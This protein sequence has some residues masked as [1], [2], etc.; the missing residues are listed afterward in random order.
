MK[1]AFIALLLA[2]SAFAQGPSGG[3]TSACGPKDASFDV[4]LDSAQHTLTQPEPGKALVYFIQEKGPD[5]FAATTKVGLD[6][7][8]VGANKNDS[9]FAVPVEPGEHHV[10]E[11]MQ[12]FR[13]HLLG[14]VHFTAEAGKN[15][16]F[17]AQ[18]IFGEESKPHLFLAAADSD[19]ATYLIE[20]F[21]LSVSTP[22][23]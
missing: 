2:T 5:S 14:L 9:Y 19:Q 18:I 8:W 3:A 15:Y 13:G 21:P 20:S 6:G 10:C 23:K 4:K 11:N 12:S 17:G 1:I 7:A 22:K 16:Y